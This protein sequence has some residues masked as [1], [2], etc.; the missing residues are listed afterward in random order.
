MRVKVAEG[1]WIDAYN[2]HADAGYHINIP[3]FSKLSAEPHIAQHQQ[4]T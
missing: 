3:V 2:L 4:T 1:V